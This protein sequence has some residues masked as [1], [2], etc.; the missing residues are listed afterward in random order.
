MGMIR[1][2]IHSPEFD[3]S[4]VRPRDNEGEGGVEGG[5]VNPPVVTLQDVLDHGVRHPEQVCLT[6]GLDPVLYS[7]GTRGHILLSQSC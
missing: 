2:T 4:I 5:P 7:P 1:I 3:L 6:G